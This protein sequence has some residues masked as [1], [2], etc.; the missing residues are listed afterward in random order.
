MART[1]L[2]T[3]ASSG[4]GRA[5]AIRLAAEGY[6]LVLVARSRERLEQVAR[7]TGGEARPCDASDGDA[8]LA[9][10]RDS[11]DVDVLV[12]AAG[13][14]AWKRVEETPPPEALEMMRAPYLAA[15]NFT[16]AVLPGMLAR[17]AGVL[18]HVGSPAS[19]VP[20]PSSAGY[21]AARF[22]LRGLNEALR[23]DLHGSGVHS[24]H[25]VFGKVNSPYF[26][27]NENAE[28]RFPGVG[29]LVRAIS[30]EEA[31]GVI[32]DTVRRPR[33]EVYHPL[34]LRVNRGLFAVAPGLT[35]WLLRTTGHSR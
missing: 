17:K 30:P 8:A 13:A 26:E 1:A 16:H 20:W 32:W 15:F 2:I 11:G 10:A 34:M 5:T 28:D 33:P 31:A 25:V 7:E 35:R 14:G 21:A 18:I 22:A 24:C 12:N 29:R 6:R 4:I 19:L 3:G 9:V 23:Q 27:T